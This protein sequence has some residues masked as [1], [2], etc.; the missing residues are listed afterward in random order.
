MSDKFGKAHLK[1]DILDPEDVVLWI[2]GKF[3]GNVG[4][5]VQAVGQVFDVDTELAVEMAKRWNE[6]ADL[7]AENDRL[8]KEGMQ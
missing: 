8:R 4:A 6:Y 5:R 7:K 2:D 3:A 1:A